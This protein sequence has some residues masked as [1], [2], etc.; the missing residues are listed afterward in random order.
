MYVPSERPVRDVGLL[1]LHRLRELLEVLDRDLD[2]SHPAQ[3]GK[4]TEVDCT[5]TDSTVRPG[6]SCWESCSTH[7]S[8]GSD[9][10]A[11]QRYKQLN[12]RPASAATHRRPTTASS[13]TERTSTLQ[14]LP[15]PRSKSEWSAF[16]ISS[17]GFR[18]QL[19]PSLTRPRI[20]EK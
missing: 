12:Y 16:L 15:R 20:A 2:Q 1:C 19:F 5:R 14:T 8:S 3:L 10:V 9:V 13:K 18:L 17:N 4:A 6:K 7:F 11:C